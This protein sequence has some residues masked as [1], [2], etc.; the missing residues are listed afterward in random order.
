MKKL[1]LYSA[2]I[3][4]FLLNTSIISA[5]EQDVPAELP[6]IEAKGAILM[7]FDSMRVLYEKNADQPLANASTTKIM[8]AIVAI[9]N[10]ALDEVVTA[11]KK[12]SQTPPTKMYLAE[13]EK[14][15][16]EDLLYALML[17]SANDAAVA[18]AE[19]VGGSVE[20]FCKMMTDRA[21]ELGA[22]NTV[23]K[24]P[25]GLDLEDHHS[26]ARDLAIIARH[27][28]ANKDFLKITQ[29]KTVK[30]P[31]RG[32]DFKS[33]TFNNKDRLLYEF[34]GALG[35][36]TGYTGKA[37][38][39]FVGAAKR[40]GMML[41]SVVLASGWGAKGKEQKWVDTKSILNYG[42]K[43]YEYV[44]LADKDSLVKEVGVLNS[45]NQTVNLKIPKGLALPLAKGEKETIT[46]KVNL[47]EVLDA[48][49]NKGQKVGFIDYFVS[50]EPLAK[51]D[52]I[53][54]SDIERYDFK[55]SMG[56]I[57]QTLLNLNLNDI[58]D[59]M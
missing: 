34:D 24:T 48:P 59:V 41:I 45:K 17:E 28:L 6:N 2:I 29:T 51:V 31:V 32:G 19:H 38:H 1:I 13:G 46:Y 36:K 27:A 10:C 8:T 42:F 12:A 20:N 43:N 4:I 18:I 58:S 47:P 3:S 56:K 9:E 57:L 44:K 33:Y 5:K 52:I 53:A 23:F 22:T 15:R 11:S 49:V 7:E 55:I 26:T 25:N 30:T 14:Q 39:C 16:M 37:G 40:D 50:G 54:E 21:K 35:V